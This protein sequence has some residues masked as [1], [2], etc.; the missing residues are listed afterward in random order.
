MRTGK[1]LLFAIL[2]M[3][4]WAMAAGG[5]GVGQWEVFETSF[6]TAKQYTNAFVEIEVNVVFSQGDRKWVVPAFWAGDKTWTVR[7]APPAQGE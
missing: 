2:M 5:A 7:F 4:F 1:L 6:E 3:P